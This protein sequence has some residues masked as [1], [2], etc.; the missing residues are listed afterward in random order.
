M[1]KKKKKDDGR[2]VRVSGGNVG[3]GKA[4]R[5]EKIGKLWF[6]IKPHTAKETRI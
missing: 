4:N 6:E 2:Y 1:A 5:C 3:I